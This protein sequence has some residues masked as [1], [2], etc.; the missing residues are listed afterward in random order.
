MERTANGNRDKGNSS[1][2]KA[3]TEQVNGREERGENQAGSNRQDGSVNH[4]HST[5]PTS[6]HIYIYI[7]TQLPAMYVCIHVCKKEIRYAFVESP[8]RS[9]RKVFFLWG[10]REMKIGFFVSRITFRNFT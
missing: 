9:R 7:Y 3:P 6:I 4:A 2:A 10:L 1:T 5:P 8:L